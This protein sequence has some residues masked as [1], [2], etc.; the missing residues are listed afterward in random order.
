M[1]L[2]KKYKTLFK[3]N[4]LTTP[5]RIAHFMAQIHHESGLETKRESLYYKTVERAKRVF[6]SPF[7]NRSHLFVSGYLENTK[8][9]AN[10]VYANRGGNGSELSGDGYKYR[11]GGFIGITF[12][13]NYQKLSDDTGI[14]FVGNPELINIEANA[15]ISALWYWNK[16]NL[17]KHADLDDLDAI[18]DIINIGRETKSE[19]DANG[20]KHRKELLKYYKIILC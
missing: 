12:K 5:L 17:N 19:G 6:Y 10:Y 18:S 4:N 13:N 8:K 7:K 16:N 14:D 3:N 1:E 2:H 20:Y 9:M 15:M 11:A